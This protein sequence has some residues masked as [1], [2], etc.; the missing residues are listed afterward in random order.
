MLDKFLTND[1]VDAEQ[2]LSEAQEASTINIATT[3]LQEAR[4]YAQNTFDEIGE[5][6]DNLLPNFDQNYQFWQDKINSKAL[7]IARDDMP[8]INPEDMDE[9]QKNINQGHVDVFKP[10]AKGDFKFP[11]N[12]LGTKNDEWLTLG[13]ED[14]KKEDDV[15][16]VTE[17]RI[18]AEKLSPIQ[19]EIWLDQV[20]PKMVEFGVPGQG[21]PVTDLP[22]IINED[23]YIIDGHHRVSQALLADRSLQMKVIK[24]PLDTDKFLQLTRAY[25]RAI[26]NTPNA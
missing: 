14:G 17:S 5:D 20:I 24:V 9:F 10:F 11:E 19:D 16:Q 12:S 6:L 8:V 7:G 4:E 23:N 21:S 15:I 22:L 1:D 25:M 18:A 2:L 26:G 13:T 3:P